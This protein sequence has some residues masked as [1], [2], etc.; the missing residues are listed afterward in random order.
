MKYPKR[1]N[2][3][4]SS[5]EASLRVLSSRRTLITVVL[6]FL[7]IWTFG[8]IFTFTELF[9]DSGNDGLV[10]GVSAVE[11]YEEGSVATSDMKTEQYEEDLDEIDEDG[12]IDG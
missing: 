2:R 5:K 7:G 10:Q 6:A 12:E 3:R 9:D 1:S 4:G 11:A 8:T